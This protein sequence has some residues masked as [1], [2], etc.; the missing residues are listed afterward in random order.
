MG[1]TN[2]FCRDPTSVAMIRCH[3]KAPTVSRI[4]YADTFY[5]QKASHGKMPS[6][7]GIRQKIVNIIAGVDYPQY[8]NMVTHDQLV[9]DP[10]L[11]E[12]SGDNIVIKSPVDISV[13]DSS[14]NVVLGVDGDGNTHYDIPGA[15]FEIANGHKYVYLPSDMGSQYH[16]NLKG[17]GT[18][19]FTLID[20][21][22]EGDQAKSTQIFNDIPVTPAFSG[23]LA[24]G[25]AAKIIPASGPAINPT[26]VVQGNAALDMLAPKTTATISGQMGKQDFYRG[27]D[28]NKPGEPGFFPGWR[29]CQRRVFHRLPA[30]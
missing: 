25:N 15:S 13:T 23:A 8:A 4:N 5:F 28:N 12:L 24:I 26:S 22:I 14:G 19:T 7:D 9:G 6:A 16:V 3:L 2:L 30:G 11:C 1:R 18:G 21:K 10:S 20:E 29:G 17:S 27:K